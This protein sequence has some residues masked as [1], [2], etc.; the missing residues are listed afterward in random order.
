MTWTPDVTVT[1][2][3]IDY[4]GATLETVRVTRGRTEMYQE[5]QAGYSYCELIDL[6]GVGLG[7]QPLQQLS[8][9]VKNSIGTLIPVFTG[10]V[11]DTSASLYD[12]GVESGTPGA[13]VTTA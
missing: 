10:K 1:I 4:T 8:I 3:G 6:D 13:I 2:N 12:T 7:I 5:P 9:T 11:S